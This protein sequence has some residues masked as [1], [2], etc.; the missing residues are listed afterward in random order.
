[1]LGLNQAHKTCELFEA[2]FEKAKN[3]TFSRD[4][5]REGAVGQRSSIF[6]QISATTANRCPPFT[7]H[8]AEDVA[9]DAEWVMSNP[10]QPCHHAASILV[11]SI[12]SLINLEFDHE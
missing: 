12:G 9:Q 3:V 5:V 11:S 6:I 2:H 8:E 1:L 10:D 7:N 4:S